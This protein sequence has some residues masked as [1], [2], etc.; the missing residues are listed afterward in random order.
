M[1]ELSETVECPLCL[2]Q[3]KLKRTDV[4]ERLGV[5]DFARVAQLSAEEAFRLFQRK[6][7]DESRRTFS[8][9]DRIEAELKKASRAITSASGLVTKDRGR[10]QELCDSARVKKMPTG[11]DPSTRI[12]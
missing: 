2:G 8:D 10:L 5:G 4:L 1:K 7:G 12:G 9:L 6:H 3:G 11:C